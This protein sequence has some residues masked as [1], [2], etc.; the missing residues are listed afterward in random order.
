MV[1]FLRRW[2]GESYIMNIQYKNNQIKKICNDHSKAVK[3]LNSRVADRLHE[4][5]IFIDSAEILLDIA[6]MPAYR[7]HPLLGDRAGT[8]AIDLI[9]SSGFRLILIPIDENGN[10]YNTNDVNV[11][12]RSSST[13]I[14]LEV[15]NHYD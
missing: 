5:L 14:L 1:I 13:I 15:S 10:E 3:Q 11:I 8:F 6:N 4:V 12:Y 2:R 7:L 9:K